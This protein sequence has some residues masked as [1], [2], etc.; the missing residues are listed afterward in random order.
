MLR[1]SRPC[2]GPGGRDETAWAR[3]SHLRSQNRPFATTPELSPSGSTGP[4]VIELL[5]SVH[6]TGQGGSYRKLRSTRPI[7][8]KSDVLRVTKTKP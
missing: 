4:T 1:R 8:A 2:G 7:R 5:E 6:G 3:R